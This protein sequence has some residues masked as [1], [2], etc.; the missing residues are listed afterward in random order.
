MRQSQ[1]LGSAVHEALELIYDCD[2]GTAV[3]EDYLTT[4]LR[5]RWNT[6]KAEFERARRQLGRWD[7]SKFSPAL[8]QARW[9]VAQ[10]TGDFSV[11]SI[12]GRAPPGREKMMFSVQS[13]NFCSFSSSSVMA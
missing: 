5:R 6:G 11:E 9:G 13:K 1:F 12:T 3:P 4:L 8:D 7:E 10:A 2:F